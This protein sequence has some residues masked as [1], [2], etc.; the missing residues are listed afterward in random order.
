MSYEATKRRGGSFNA[1]C[2]VKE[3]FLDTDI[4]PFT[5]MT[6]KWIMKGCLLYDYSYRSFWKR[7]NYRD[8]KKVS[9]CQGFREYGNGEG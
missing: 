7:Q 9:G 2:R 5:K 3:V 6:S 1:C 4:M 8:G